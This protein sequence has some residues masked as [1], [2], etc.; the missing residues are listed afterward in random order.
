MLLYNDKSYYGPPADIWSCGVILYAMLCGYLPYDDDP[1]NP[2]SGNINLLYRYIIST[3]LKFSPHLDLD[4]RCLLASILTVNPIAR[5]TI[6]DI[7]NSDWFKKWCI[8]SRRNEEFEEDALNLS[9]SM[10]S[11]ASSSSSIEISPVFKRKKPMFYQKLSKMFGSSKQHLAYQIPMLN[12]Y[13]SHEYLYSVQ[14]L[15][16]HKQIPFNHIGNIFICRKK[17]VCFEIEYQMQSFVMKFNSGSFKEF[18]TIVD[19]ISQI[20]K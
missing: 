12:G 2:N 5:S 4:I 9:S 3:P 17:S 15:L 1:R 18:M 10:S 8:T 19:E 11:L 16:I 20:G 13:V 6:R 14:L 7:K